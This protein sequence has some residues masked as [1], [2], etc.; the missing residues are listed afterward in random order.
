MEIN[1]PVVDELMDGNESVTRVYAFLFIRYFVC[2]QVKVTV[3]E[4][5][6]RLET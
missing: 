1:E 5:E 2:Q 3:N 6:G 4:D